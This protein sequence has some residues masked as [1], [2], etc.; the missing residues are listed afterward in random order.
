MWALFYILGTQQWHKRYFLFLTYILEDAGK[1]IN[2]EYNV[3]IPQIGWLKQEIYLLTVLK[4]G[5]PRSRC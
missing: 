2:I 1:H 4:P 3:R 5:N